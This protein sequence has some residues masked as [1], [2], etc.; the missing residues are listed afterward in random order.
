MVL[1]P[2]PAAAHWRG[3]AGEAGDEPLKP[4]SGFHFNM[5]RGLLYFSITNG[6]AALSFI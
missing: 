1:A 5:E 4:V 6:A 3:P 2:S